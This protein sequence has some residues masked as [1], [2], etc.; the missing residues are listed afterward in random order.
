MS[1]VKLDDNWDWHPKLVRA[2]EIAQWLW[3]KCLTYACKFE[4]DGNVPSAAVSKMHPKAGALVNELVDVGL[5]RKTDSGIVIHDFLDWNFSRAERAEERKRANDR[6]FKS[7]A[8]KRPT[9]GSGHENVTRDIPVTTTNV[10][11]P[12]HS[13]VTLPSASASASAIS[14]PPVCPPFGGR[15]TILPGCDPD[16][17]PVPVQ[18]DAQA[19]PGS[20]DGHRTAECNP[21]GSTPVPETKTSGRAKRASGKPRATLTFAPEQFEVT[22]GLYESGAK[23]GLTRA[24]VESEVDKF[25]DHHRAKGNQFADWAAAF[26]TWMG[27]ANKFSTGSTTQFAAAPIGRQHRMAVVREDVPLEDMPSIE[28]VLATNLDDT[29]QEDNQ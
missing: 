9:D 19:I 2:S 18:T 25:L 22:E 13:G 8:G 27:N 16:S 26:R 20:V 11:A 4:T 29:T 17:A 28:T 10:T 23:R 1:W 6:K 5:F 3:I 14:D 21:N 7:R 12:C 15:Q 24:R